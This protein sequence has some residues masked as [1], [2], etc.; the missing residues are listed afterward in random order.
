MGLLDPF[1]DLQAVHPRHA[2]V[3]DNDITGLAVQG[4]QGLW[5]AF[6]FDYLEMALAQAVGQGLAKIFLIVYQ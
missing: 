4:F 2:N 3:Q 1:Q 6:R 5:S